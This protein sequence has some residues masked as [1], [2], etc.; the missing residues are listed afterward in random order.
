MKGRSELAS[1]FLA[2][3]VM[4][5]PGVLLLAHHGSRVSYDLTKTVTFKG[6]IKEVQYV[7]PHVYFLFDVK[8][9]QG[10]VTEW[11]AE[12]DP[13]IM[14]E[15]RYG[16]SK[17]YL[18]TGDEVTVTMWPSKVGAPRGF[19]AKLV[20]ADGKVLDHTEQPQQ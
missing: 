14:L 5:G 13:P 9:A 4:L 15:R 19:L 20:T 8:D 3:A 16:W 2:I 17:K 11:G 1:V 6:K 18:K 12:T 10:N 7:N